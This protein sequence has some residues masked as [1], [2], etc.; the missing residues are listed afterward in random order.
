MPLT[1]GTR[2]GSYEIVSALGAGGMGEVYRAFDT[3]LRRTVAIKILVTSD[4]DAG[5]RLL[6]E[7]RAASTLNHPNVCTVHEVGYHD[8][9]SF[10]VMELV[11]GRPLSQVIAS[12]DLNTESVLRYSIQIADALAHAHDNGTIHRDLKSQNVVVTPGGH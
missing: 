3:K 2:L 11:E 5:A 10:I 9:Q 4:D 6:E 1:P 8:G 12:K 7:A